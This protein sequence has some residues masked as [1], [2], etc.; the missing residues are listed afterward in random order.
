[1]PYSNTIAN[2][3]FIFE[4]ELAMLVGLQREREYLVVL[5]IHSIDAISQ[6]L[7]TGDISL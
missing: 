3:A 5:D 1:M 6:L 7:L 2:S 4:R